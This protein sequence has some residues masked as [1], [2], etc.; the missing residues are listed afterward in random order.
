M[1]RHK[2]IHLDQI[3]KS[4]I[5]LAWNKNRSYLINCLELVEYAC[6][7]CDIQSQNEM[8]LKDVA[9]KLEHVCLDKM[10]QFKDN[11][12]KKG[13]QFKVLIIGLGERV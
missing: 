8:E 12:A 10:L 2:C 3:S 6:D 11:T 7:L 1:A 4:S 5:S 13:R 9:Y